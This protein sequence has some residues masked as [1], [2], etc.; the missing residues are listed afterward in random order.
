M[1]YVI[2]SVKVPSL[3]IH[4]WLPKAMLKHQ[5]RQCITCRYLLKLGSQAS[6]VFSLFISNSSFYFY[7]LYYNCCYFN[8]ISSFTVYVKMILNVLQLFFNCAYEF[9]LG[10]FCERS[11]SYSGSLLLQIA[12]GLSSS[13]LFLVQECYMIV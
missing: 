3:P 6:Y 1:L 4:L 11:Y 5:R 13:A 12:H 10:P 9:L 8:H 2:V 7:H